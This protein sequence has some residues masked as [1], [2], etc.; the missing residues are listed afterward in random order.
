[1]NETGGL[2]AEDFRLKTETSQLLRNEIQRHETRKQGN[3]A[4]LKQ[5]PVTGCHLG[6]PSG[7]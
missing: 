3:T 2:N 7:R 1:M 6:F 5:V 4:N